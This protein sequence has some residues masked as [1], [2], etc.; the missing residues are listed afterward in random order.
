MASASFDRVLKTLRG[1]ADTYYP[2]NRRV[3]V[4]IVQQ[5]AGDASFVTPAGCCCLEVP[6]DTA[7]PEPE[8][9]PLPGAIRQPGCAIACLAV[10][11]ESGQPMQA[12]EVEEALRGHEKYQEYSL[13]SVEKAML[14]LG[15]VG[16]V[17][18][19]RNARSKG[20][21]LTDG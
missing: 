3:A 4:V 21:R 17:H 6:T 2:G 8:D 9:G 14:D 13:S 18:N 20:Y 7:L 11:F 10:L 16:L 19:P 5:S 1:F 15:K 12:S